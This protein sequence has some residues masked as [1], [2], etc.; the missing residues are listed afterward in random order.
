MQEPYTTPNITR[1][2]VSGYLTSESRTPENYG[3]LFWVSTFFHVARVAH[4]GSIFQYLRSEP[5]FLNGQFFRYVL[6]H[7][8]L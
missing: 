8:R 2:V 1:G 4:N 3:C 7:F 6:S 5:L